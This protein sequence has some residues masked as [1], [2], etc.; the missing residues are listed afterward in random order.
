VGGVGA[1]GGGVGVSGWFRV[2]VGVGWKDVS[3]GAYR[4]SFLLKRMKGER[5]IVGVYLGMKWDTGILSTP[6]V[7]KKEEDE[8]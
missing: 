3:A 2:R 4:R 7:T 8:G 1:R 6:L 5:S